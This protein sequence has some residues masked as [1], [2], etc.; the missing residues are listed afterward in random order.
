MPQMI[1]Q[2]TRNELD[3]I[4]HT[5]LSFLDDASHRTVVRLALTRIEVLSELPPDFTVASM[6]K[7]AE[8]IYDWSL[9]TAIKVH[10]EEKLA[11][12]RVSVLAEA[13]AGA[14]EKTGSVAV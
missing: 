5:Q 8:E 13:V 11:A 7:Q 10:G 12:E 6:V 2:L 1:E 3:Q 9:R 14:R 4:L